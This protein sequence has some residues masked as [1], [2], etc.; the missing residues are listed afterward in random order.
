MSTDFVVNKR[1][2]KEVV[3]TER[4][5][6]YDL[7]L[8]GYTWTDLVE[9]PQ[10]MSADEALNMATGIIYAIWCSHPDKANA[11]AQALAKD[12]PAVGDNR[13]H[14]SSWVEESQQKAREARKAQQ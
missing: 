8:Y 1:G 12:I 9:G 4:S 13:E 7:D 3:I 14:I 6:L 5:A 10:Q 11:I 2:D